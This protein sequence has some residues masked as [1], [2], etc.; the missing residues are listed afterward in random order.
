MPADQR[1]VLDGSLSRAGPAG[2]QGLTGEDVRARIASGRVNALP[3]EPTRTLLQILRANVLTRFNAI[4]MTLFVVI[5][6]VGPLQDALFGM[7]VVLNT[8]IGVL[9]ELRAKRTLDRLAVVG[10]P[11]A[12]AV[13]DG[14]VDEVAVEEIVQD[15]VL[16]LRG[17]DQVPVDGV[18]VSGSAEVD[19]SL[20]SGEAEP[21]AKSYGEE[22]LS[23]SIVV[24]GSARYRASRVGTESY[25]QHLTSEARRFSLVHSELQ[26]GTNALLR[27]I[28]WAIAPVALILVLGQLTREGAD[29]PDAI[30]GTVAGV[31]S[32]IPE[33]LVL[34]TSLAFALAV[35]RLAG[36]RVLVQELASVEGLA[37]VDTICLD[38]TGTLTQGRISCDALDP[39]LPGVPAEQALGA[40][41]RADPNPNASL[42]AV[43]ERFGDPGNWVPERLVAFSSAR[44]WG[45]ASFN[46]RGTWVLGAPDVL[47]GTDAA[48]M[49]RVE[50][51][52]SQGRRVLLLARSEVPLAVDGESLPEGIEPAALVTLVERMRPDVDKTI[53]YFVNQGVS[54]KVVSGDHP[55]TVA[56]IARRAGVPEADAAMDGRDL[57]DDPGELAAAM[58]RVSVVGRVKPHQKR[59]IVQALQS[60]G[61]TVGMT[62]DGVNDV[63]ALKDADIGVAMGAGSS[64]TRA[65]AQLVLLS[66]SFD[67][68][69]G[70]V[71]EGRRVIANVERVANLFVTKTVYATLIALAIGAIEEPFPFL[72]RHLTVVSTLTIGLP[73]LVLALPPNPSRFRPGFVR[74]T[75]QFTLPSGLLAGGVTLIVYSVARASPGLGLEQARSAATIALFVEGLW[76]LLILMRPYTWWKIALAATMA[77]A[78][79]GA[80]LIVPVSNVLS[81]T[82]PSGSVLVMTLAVS[83]AGG[84]LLEGVEPALERARASGL[85]SG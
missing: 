3:S 35:V 51:H 84:L 44:K 13:R 18:V 82:A 34:L 74:R 73:A 33:G 30:R 24:S 27:G 9:Q 31:G 38:K 37:R 28:T 53:G 85:L 15:D 77:L 5:L 46:G 59:A 6:V 78:F 36:S 60:E 52:A 76:V 71:A 11:R 10:K 62:G 32:M 47:A 54:V 26:A 43:A 79:A 68:V 2:E 58:S 66:N 16:E 29:L 45:G 8:G 63:L 39:L 75:L 49:D 4:L 1:R 40:L 17:G 61:H 70:V 81:L 72:P 21:V 25:A 7:V 12:H 67:A 80:F 56:A 14:A 48:L 65:V 20:L 42:S 41:S 57:P 50:E 22:L 23:G 64:A 83:A 55:L 69:P 19:E